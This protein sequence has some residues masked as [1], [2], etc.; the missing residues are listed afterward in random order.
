MT[1]LDDN[2]VW[3]LAIRK[4]KITNG[5]GQVPSTTAVEV[6]QRFCLDGDEQND[7]DR[8]LRQGAI[9]LYGGTPE[10][11]AFIESKKQE[12]AEA[13]AKANRRIGRRGKNG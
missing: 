10:E 13:A 1:Q 6:G 11:D 5:P 9:R 3:Y 8:L 2:E 4:L 7:F 12:R